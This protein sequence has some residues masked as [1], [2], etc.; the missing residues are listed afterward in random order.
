M[1]TRVAMASARCSFL[2]AVDRKGRFD[3]A[4]D[5]TVDAK[6]NV[7]SEVSDSL[8]PPI[9]KSNYNKEPIPARC[10]QV[11]PDKQRNIGSCSVDVGESGDPVTQVC[12]WCSKFFAT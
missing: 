11:S 12:W 5:I 10:K 2:N 7:C 1:S 8:V 3:L 4:R 9:R 6:G